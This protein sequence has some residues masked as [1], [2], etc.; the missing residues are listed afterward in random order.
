MWLKKNINAA[1]AL[2]FRH[3]ELL[4]YLFF[5]GL[6]TLVSAVSYFIASWGFGASA[7][8][9]SVI[10]W[11]FAVTF[12]FFTNKIFVFKSKTTEKKAAQREV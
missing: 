2:W 1:K 12:A 6:T 5:G 4:L 10:S 11:F 7:W 9:S 8:L 3:E